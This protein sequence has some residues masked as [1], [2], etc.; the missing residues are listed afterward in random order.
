[1]QKEMKI[2]KATLKKALEKIGFF[3]GK[4]QIDANVSCVHFK[5]KDKKAVLFAHDHHKAGRL[6]ID[7]NEEGEF[8]FVLDYSRFTKPLCMR[9]KEI[10]IKLVENYVNDEGMFING[11]EFTDGRTHECFGLNDSNAFAAP[12]MTSVVPEGKSGLVMEAKQIKEGFKSGGCARNEKE[13]QKI[14]FTGIKAMYDS[15]DMFVFSTNQKRIACWQS[16][17]GFFDKAMQGFDNGDE[18]ITNSMLS[19]EAIRAIELFDDSETISLYD[20]GKKSIFVSETMQMFIEK[21]SGSL[22]SRS[23][24]LKDRIL[25][26]PT[27]AS[28]EATRSEFLES[29]KIVKNDSDMIT[30]KFHDGFATFEGSD[31]KF[32]EKVN[33]DGFEVHC[34]DGKDITIS[35]SPSMFIDTFENIVDE[36]IQFDM[37]KVDDTLTAI[38]YSTEH[39]SFGSFAPRISGNR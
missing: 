2:E 10:T 9:G 11:I 31:R 15:D 35:I 39:G 23:Q 14:E 16:S 33:D 3:V 32:S 20:D 36:K 27:I 4:M 12:E 29:L 22:D 19:P 8:E 26:S 28:Y 21:I 6:F 24:I 18:S 37:K 17:D 38:C 7:T 13:K 25:A 5:N 30:V 1:M 34:L